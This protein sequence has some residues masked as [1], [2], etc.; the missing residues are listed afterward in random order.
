MFFY[1]YSL[2]EPD[3]VEVA[4]RTRSIMGTWGANADYITIQNLELKNAIYHG[5]LTNPLNDHWIIAGNTVHHNGLL[6]ELSVPRGNNRVGI[7]VYG[8]DYILVADN[9]I[10]DTG[11]NGVQVVSSSN[12]IVERNIIHDA[13]H[14]G[15]DMKGGGGSGDGNN[16]IRHNVVYT[17]TSKTVNV[18]GIVLT[19]NDDLQNKYVLHD[20]DVYGNLVYGF[21]ESNGIE[22]YGA[23]LSNINVYNNTV[24][25]SREAFDILGV[26]GPVTV[27]NNIGIGSGRSL[28]INNSNNAS[29]IIDYNLWQGTLQQNSTTYANLSLWRAATPYDDH[30]IS[31][32]P[33]FANAAAYDFSLVSSSPAIDAGANVG[34]ST[35]IVGN[36]IPSGNGYDIGAYEFQDGAPSIS[37]F[38]IPASSTSAT[39]SG[40]SLSATDDMG[41]TGYLVN[42]SASQP[43]LSDPGWSATPPTSY[44]LSGSGSHILYAWA[45][46]ATGHI[47][48]SVSDT[49]IVTIPGTAYYVDASGGNDSNSGTSPENAWRTIAKVNQFSY[50]SSSPANLQPGDSILFKRG[51]IWREMLYL[52]KFHPTAEAPV[53]IGA[54]GSG[55]LPIINGAQ[56]ITNWSDQGGNVWRASVGWTNPQTRGDVEGPNIPSPEVLIVNGERGAL[57]ANSGSLSSAGDW[58]YDS[59]N[60]YLYLYSAS[61]PTDVELPVWPRAVMATWFADV[62]H[63]ILENL[64][65]KN[66]LYHLLTVRPGNDNWIVRN[67]VGHHN[68]EINAN[69]EGVDRN[70]YN[71]N[72]SDNTVISGNTVYEAGA[73]GI[74][75]IRS[76]NVTVEDNTV[77]NSYHH[78]IDMKGGNG[79][80]GNVIRN[81]TVYTTDDYA[82]T[83]LNGIVLTDDDDGQYRPTSDIQVYGNAIYNVT[84]NGLLVYGSTTDDILI[85]NNV[86]YD[87]GRGIR[88]R[89]ANGSIIVKNNIGMSSQ[90]GWHPMIYI[91][92]AYSMSGF[93]LDHNLWYKPASLAEKTFGQIDAT[94]YSSVASWQS[95]GRDAHSVFVDPSFLDLGNFDFRLS[96]GSPAIDAGTDVGLVTDKSGNGIPAGSAPDIGIYEFQDAL[97]PVVTSFSIP[98]TSESTTVPITSFAA[99]DNVAVTGYLVNESSSVPSVNDPS[100]Q[101]SAVAVYLFLQDGLRTLYAWAKDASGN[102]SGSMSDSVNITVPDEPGPSSNVAPAVSLTS[103]ADG[104]T[105]TAGNSVTVAATASDLDGSVIDVKFYANGS[106]LNTDNSAPYSYS[107]SPA[108]NNYS[109]IAVATDDDGDSATSSAVSLTVNNS[110]SSG[111][112]GGWYI[113]PTPPASTTTS[114][115][116]Q[117]ATT[118]DDS[119]QYLNMVADLPYQDNVL[120]RDQSSGRV[121]EI[122][123]GYRRYVSTLAELKML[124]KIMRM[125]NVSP[126]VI[127]LYPEALPYNDALLRDP[128][129]GKVYLALNYR[130]WYIG[131]LDALKSLLKHYKLNNVSMDLID[132]Y[133]DISRDKPPRWDGVILLDAVSNKAHLV[134]GD[135]KEYLSSFADL[136]AAVQKYQTKAVTPEIVDMYPNRLPY[137]DKALVKG[138]SSDKIYR[139]DGGHKSYVSTISELRSLMSQGYQLH[140]IRDYVIDEYPDAY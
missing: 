90:E 118:T 45:K 53:T 69:G 114:T 96:A 104:S 111:G 74:M 71:F 87:C 51:E 140:V 65:F 55:A 99:A 28:Y 93:V 139:I 100:W 61:S 91:D 120:L 62:D 44:V 38:S 119:W 67:T 52:Q 80:H 124:Q 121:F 83:T 72:D 112:G 88:L 86:V 48:A 24:Y 106:L 84:V 46:D 117:I 6:D 73:N 8:G 12:S 127:Y 137:H 105:V 49:V 75:V 63:V 22:I 42:E 23:T 131:A 56:R 95:S 133:A 103:P 59:G 26:G 115:Q 25:D 107:W 85:S 31:T 16:V 108:A 101:S 78:N 9:Y 57:K 130:K 39:I 76:S 98:E 82:G 102:I 1:L 116:N 33:G 5:I 79:A 21:S 135:E 15:I 60:S 134:V 113:P 109:I 30:S 125:V 19:D 132:A 92:E 40:I 20:V 10:H 29:N 66:T 3:D 89:K 94:A 35:D 7:S 11:E 47:S 110:S 17:D 123:D 126:D 68:G 4:A 129:S 122:D 128:T 32:G 34:L 54:Y 138:S 14:H 50:S 81:N 97:S 18:N 77:Y 136:K 43:S 27:R 2:L 70:G 36:A 13:H 37:S 41:V 64:E 58:Y